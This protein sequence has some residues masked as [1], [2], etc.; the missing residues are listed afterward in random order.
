MDQNTNQ[1]GQQ[2][3]RDR[4]QGQQGQQGQQCLSWL[5]AQSQRAHD[6]TAIL[7][8]IEWLVFSAMTQSHRAL[9]CSSVLSSLRTKM[10]S[11]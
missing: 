4:Q 3:D 2:Q 1:P 6:R 10:A 8:A 7:I 5:I 9:P 11:R